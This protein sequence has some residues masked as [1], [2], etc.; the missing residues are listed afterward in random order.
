[1][2][3]RR[4]DNDD[5]LGIPSDAVYAVGRLALASA[6]LETVV[7]SVVVQCGGDPKRKPASVVAEVLRDTDPT[8]VE[9]PIPGETPAFLDGN[10]VPASER[11]AWCDA[12]I[13][14]M[15]ARGELIHS[16]PMFTI[17]GTPSLKQVRPGTVTP[18]DVDAVDALVS[19]VVRLTGIGFDFMCRITASVPVE[20][21]HRLLQSVD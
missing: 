2:R 12:V 9:L 5:M 4:R 1:M 21:Q 19:E 10:A 20:D 6:Q 17:E 14:A 16:A 15:A 7:R 18:I 13:E 3:R 11:A 8:P